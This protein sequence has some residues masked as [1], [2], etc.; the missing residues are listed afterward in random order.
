MSESKSCPTQGQESLLGTS[1]QWRRCLPSTHSAP[2]RSSGH[3][4]R[5]AVLFHLPAV[6]SINAWI[7]AAFLPTCWTI[8]CSSLTARE[9]KCE[10][11]WGA[12]SKRSGIVIDPL[13]PATKAGVCAAVRIESSVSGAGGEELRM[14]S[15]ACAISWATFDAQSPTHTGNR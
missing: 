10:S 4:L 3:R 8:R 5:P 15:S 7:R 13:S 2:S 12:H 6:N 1:T 14:L 11:V 9:V